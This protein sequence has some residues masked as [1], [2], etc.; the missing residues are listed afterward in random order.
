VDSILVKHRKAIFMNKPKKI[1][2]SRIRKDDKGEFIYRHSFLNGKQKLTKVYLVDGVPSDEIKLYDLY[3]ENADDITLSQ[4]GEY[5]E[6]HSRHTDSI[7]K[8]EGSIDEIPF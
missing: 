7:Q 8:S 6:L 1:R 4:E 3:L 2:K 5:G